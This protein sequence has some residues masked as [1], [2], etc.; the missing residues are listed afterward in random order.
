MKKYPELSERAMRVV[1]VEAEHYTYN[2]TKITEI[3]K[4]LV[5]LCKNTRAHC[6][7]FIGSS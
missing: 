4:M 2:N 1:F 6:V 5:S 3:D 7:W